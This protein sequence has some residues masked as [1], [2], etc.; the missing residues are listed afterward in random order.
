MARL[1]EQRQ[2][3]VQSIDEFLHR[4]EHSQVPAQPPLEPEDD[5]SRAKWLARAV[6]LM[7][8]V[9]EPV[10]L[11]GGVV[12]AYAMIG[13]Y[14]EDSEYM[15]ARLVIML[16]VVTAPTIAL[17]IA[18]QAARLGSMSGTIAFLVSASV[19]GMS[20]FLFADVLLSWILGWSL[21]VC[22][23]LFVVWRYGAK[24]AVLR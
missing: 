2:C 18:V 9:V 24:P 19:L 15:G 20:L 12:L 13:Y 10:L 22:V 3:P 11:L 5:A 6:W 7:I 23:L 4:P 17:L 16:V 21:L 14:A 8:A 1:M